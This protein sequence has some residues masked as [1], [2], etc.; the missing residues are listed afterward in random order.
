MIR[1]NAILSSAKIQFF[2]SMGRNMFRFCVIVQP[3]LMGLLLGMMY[4]NSSDID[5]TT[6]ALLGSGVSTFW[7]SICFSSAS[8]IQRERWY[9]TL[10][11]IYIAPIGF[12]SVIFGKILGNSLAGMMSTFISFLTVSLVYRRPIVLAHPFYFVLSIIM[13]M[14]CFMIIGF[15]MASF[16]TLSR[17]SRILMNFLE[18]PIF[19]LCGF[20]FPIQLLPIYLQW[21]SNILAPTWAMKFIRFS[22]TGEG[23]V[24]SLGVL[25]VLMVILYLAS[26]LV[27]REIDKKCRVDATLGVY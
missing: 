16:F 24:M 12:T 2:S 9:G 27:Y 3:V 17:N 7:T 1:I 20:L 14:L 21:F 26:K 13:L 11:N 8:D 18:Y 23:S 15:F 4:I 25:I 6:Y 19:I 10:E 5:F 22:V